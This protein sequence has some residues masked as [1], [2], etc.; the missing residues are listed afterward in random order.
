MAAAA[1]KKIDR[2]FKEARRTK[3]DR[4]GKT[5]ALCAHGK[6][7][8]TS[9]HEGECNRDASAATKR[10]VGNQTIRRDMGTDNGTN[11]TKRRR[12]LGTDNG[13]YTK[14]QTIRR[15]DYGY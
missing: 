6:Q 2:I 4:N 12:D 9:C 10:S 7:K 8:A 14:N 15:D 11:N 3:E 13:T 1:D 5:I